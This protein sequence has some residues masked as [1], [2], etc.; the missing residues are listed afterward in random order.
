MTRRKSYYTW[1]INADGTSGEPTPTMA[2]TPRE[3]AENWATFEDG[4]HRRLPRIRK[5]IDTPTVIVVD[6]E[7]KWRFIVSYVAGKYM[8]REDCYVDAA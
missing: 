5:G 7:K 2:R 4:I 1:G 3:A 8:A 6:G